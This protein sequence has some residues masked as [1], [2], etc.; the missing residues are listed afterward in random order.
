MIF[1]TGSILIVGMCEESILNDIYYFLTNLLKTEFEHIC[2]H[3]IDADQISLK[4]KKKNVRRKIINIMITDIDVPVKNVAKPQNIIFEEIV[5][6]SNK[7]TTVKNPKK[8]S[9]KKNNLIV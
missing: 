7:D 6:D 4:N 3:L 5:S 1:R 8:C 9:Y 2:Q